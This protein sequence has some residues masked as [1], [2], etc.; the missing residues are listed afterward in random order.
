MNEIAQFLGKQAPVVISP[1]GFSRVPR[2]NG[3]PDVDVSEILAQ[4][5]LVVGFWAKTARNNDKDFADALAHEYFSLI[6][7]GPC[8]TINEHVFSGQIDWQ[9]DAV[10]SD[11]PDDAGSFASPAIGTDLKFAVLHLPMPAKSV[12]DCGLPLATLKQAEDESVSAYALRCR[13]MHQRL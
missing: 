8:P 13:S 10:P 11:A 6:C 12:Q 1:A 5:R 7:D 4:Y 9:S 3:A 2:L